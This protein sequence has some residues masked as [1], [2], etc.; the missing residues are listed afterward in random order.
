MPSI[1]PLTDIQIPSAES[2]H[3]T[4]HPLSNPVMEGVARNESEPVV[5]VPVVSMIAAPL[6][7]FPLRTVVLCYGEN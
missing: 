6:N 5:R 3:A 2:T 1:H 4:A 7:A